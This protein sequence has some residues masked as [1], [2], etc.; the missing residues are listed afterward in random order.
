[1]KKILLSLLLITLSFP[2][3]AEEDKK[4]SAFDRVMRTGVLRCGYYVFPP[5]TNRDA[6]TNDLSGFSVD[7]MNRLAERASLKIEWTEEVTFGNWVPAMQANRFD[8]V[9]TPMWPDLPQAKVVSFTHS[10]FFAG[11]YPAVLEKNPKIN[12]KMTIKDLNNETFTFVAQEGNMTL[13]TTKSA[14]PNAKLYVLPAMADGGEYYQAIA[15][16]K[17][18]AVITDANGM[19]QWNANNPENRMIFLDMSHPITLQQFPLVVKRGESDLLEFLNL[20]IDEMN[21]AGEIDKILK[22]WEPEPGKTY[23]RV[24]NPAKVQ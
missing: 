10:L 5:I 24:A 9:C 4:E 19:G 16:K 17:A 6:N 11:K 21:N 20:A 18:D 3:M 15:T 7:M 8:A 13:N 12:S 2:V 14:V 1:M 23:L 22:K